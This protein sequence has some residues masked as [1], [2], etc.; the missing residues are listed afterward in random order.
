MIGKVIGIMFMSRNMAHKAH[1]KTG[2]YSQ[3]M[4]LKEFYEEIVEY[5]DELAEK[6][7]GKYGIIEVEDIDDKGDVDSPA[8]M[9]EMH[10]KMLE[11]VCK[12]MEDRHLSAVAD[13]IM[14]LYYGTIYKVRYLK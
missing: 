6:Y 1:L 5:A 14:G 9:L 3:H 10:V 2:S 11:R 12:S 4:A 7:Q 8:E 13:E